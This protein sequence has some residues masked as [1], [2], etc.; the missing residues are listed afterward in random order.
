MTDTQ[1]NVARVKVLQSI[2]EL[3]QAAIDALR[4]WKYEPVIIDGKPKAV[5]F[6]VTIRFQLKS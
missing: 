4:Q 5:V 6:T 2:P 3:D 1:G